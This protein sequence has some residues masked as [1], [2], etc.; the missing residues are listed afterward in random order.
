MSLT[1]VCHYEPEWKRQSGLSEK[2]FLGSTITKKVY[3]CQSRLISRINV[4]TVNSV[5]YCLLLRQN[6]PYLLNDS[7]IYSFKL[8]TVIQTIL[9]SFGSFV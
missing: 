8:Y 9:G 6:S 3:V 4:A 5:P 2:N 1:C 7:C